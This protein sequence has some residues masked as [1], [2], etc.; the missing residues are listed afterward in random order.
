MKELT[1][2]GYELTSLVEVGNGE[3]PRKGSRGL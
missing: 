2:P 1:R 3:E